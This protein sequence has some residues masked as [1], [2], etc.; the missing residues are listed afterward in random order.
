V[1]RNK[2]NDERKK[3]TEKERGIQKRKNK[4]EEKDGE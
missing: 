1:N 2:M 3:M 4:G